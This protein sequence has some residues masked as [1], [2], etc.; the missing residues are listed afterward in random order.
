[1][2]GM[3]CKCGFAS[4]SEKVKCPKCGRLMKPAEWPD[5]GKVL[6]FIPLQATPEGL[7]NPYNLVLVEM[8]DK[9]PKV[10][11]WTS[12]K[13]KEDEEV[14]VTD[15]SGKLFCSPKASLKF[16]LQDVKS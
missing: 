4:V 16:V 2:K 12:G 9:G 5:D 7:D 14:S 15:R 1:M 13:L 11:C 6:S 10:V 8:A 3:K